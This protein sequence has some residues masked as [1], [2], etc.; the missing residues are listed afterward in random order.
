MTLTASWDESEQ[1]FNLFIPSAHDSGE[2]CPLTVVLHGKTATWESWFEN[3]AVCE[4]AEREGHLLAAP[5]G[6]GDWFYLGPGERDALDVIEEVKRLCRVDEDRVYLMG[7][8]MGGWGAWHL[9]CTHPDLFAAIVPMAGW[10]PL[11]LLPNA[12][13][14]SPLVIHGA[15]DEPVPPRWSRAAVERLRELEI[16][17]RHIEVPGR[18]H[19]PE[20]I[21][22]MLP[23]VGNWLQG[24]RRVRRP[25]RVRLRAHTPRRGRAH[26]LSI[27]ET[28]HCPHLAGIDCEIGEGRVLLRTSGVRR[29]TFDPHAS[30]LAGRPDF[31]VVVDHHEFPA[32]AHT[33]E[34][35]LLLQ[36]SHR[37]WMLTLLDRAQNA[38]PPSPVIGRLEAPRQNL[39][40]D[41]AEIVALQTGS[42]AA[43]MASGLVAP[44]LPAG[45]LTADLV[46]DL[47]VRP[48][49]QLCQSYLSPAEV[50]LLAE[51]LRA[52]PPWWG[53]CLIAPEV[54]RA[55]ADRAL[56]ITI[57][58]IIR[59]E[60]VGMFF[61]I[62]VRLRELLHDHVLQTGSLEARP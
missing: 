8:S 9:G 6:R 37:S 2:P 57:P 35:V 58:E 31:T 34:Q 46:V 1:P 27:H 42:H 22:E 7:H 39:A 29:F 5:H 33:E 52:L 49:D 23:E 15:E 62:R 19:G 60:G 53:E 32:P 4:W 51:R 20:M 55:P 56:L 16:E 26:H 50:A 24:R 61:P 36:R 21:S 3:T 17:H 40:R 45:D 18:G 47:F 43:V 12:E 48:E 30:P 38:P 41:V 14:L 25:S 11:D 28:G 59:A 13:H 44:E 10:A 54:D